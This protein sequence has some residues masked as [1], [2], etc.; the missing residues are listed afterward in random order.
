[1]PLLGG[2]ARATWGSLVALHSAL[3]AAEPC[4]RQSTLPVTGNPAPTTKWHSST[5][6]RDSCKATW[7]GVSWRA[8]VENVPTSGTVV[9]HV[10]ESDTSWLVARRSVVPLWID[11]GGASTTATKPTDAEAPLLPLLPPGPAT[12][13]IVVVAGRADGL[14]ATGAAPPAT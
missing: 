3:Q 7:W 11:R 8:A 10:D 13:M 9:T 2:A 14:A 5:N 12:V 6:D 4:R 1:M